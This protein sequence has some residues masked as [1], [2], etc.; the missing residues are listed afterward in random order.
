LL[1]ELQAVLVDAAVEVQGRVGD[2][3]DRPFEVHRLL[4]QAA[5]VAEH[6]VTGE[7]QVAVGPGRQDRPAVDFDAELPV[8]FLSVGSVRLE[9]QRR[10]VGVRPDDAEPGFRRRHDADDAGQ[11]RAAAAPDEKG[12]AR[13]QV[14]GIALAQFEK[15]CVSQPVGRRLNGVRRGGRGFE[16]FE[17]ILG[18][19]HDGSFPERLFGS[20]R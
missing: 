16:V 2:A 11:Q 14:P 3:A 13:A 19:A 4:A 8:A 12:V 15:A 7:G 17:Q 9:A 1:V 10:H 20:R 6:Q 18:V 5:L